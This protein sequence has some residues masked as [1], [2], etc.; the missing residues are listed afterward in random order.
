M[1]RVMAADDDDDNDNDIDVA[2]QER[3]IETKNQGKITIQKKKKMWM[4]WNSIEMR[5]V[6]LQLKFTAKFM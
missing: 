1:Q 2:R 4:I 5:K 3:S 6:K